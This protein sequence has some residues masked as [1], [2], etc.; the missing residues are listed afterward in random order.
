MISLYYKFLC[1]CQVERNSSRNAPSATDSP[2]SSA[3]S[4]DEGTAAKSQQPPTSGGTKKSGSRSESRRQKQP[5]KGEKSAGEKS[6]SEKSSGVLEDV[7]VTELMGEEEKGG[8]HLGQPVTVF[9]HMQ[10][11]AADQRELRTGEREGER[12]RGT[13][14][15]MLSEILSLCVYTSISNF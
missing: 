14:R 8:L 2:Q 3:G 9:R 11:L 6:V 5:R 13:G 7:S 1:I 10:T 4:T 15:E 12:E